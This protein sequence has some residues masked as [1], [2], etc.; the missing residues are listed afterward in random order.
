MAAEQLFCDTNVL[1]SAIDRRRT[2]HAQ[3]LHVLNV[4]PNQGV[5]L[6]VSGQVLRELVVVCTRPIEANG[7][8]MPLGSALE[9]VVAISGRCRLLEETRVVHEKLIELLRAHDVL[10]KQAHDANVVATMLTH[11]VRDLVT[12]NVGDFARYAGIGVVDLAAV[13]TVAG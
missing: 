13:E 8:G 12:A 11:G 1:L 7:L 2:L 10:G 6:C 3:A 9:N 5:A 4:L